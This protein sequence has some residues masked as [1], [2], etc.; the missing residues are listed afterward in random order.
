MERH[1]EIDGSNKDG[2]IRLSF[3]NPNPQRA[4]EIANGYVDQFR[5]LSQQLAISEAS[6]RRLIFEEQLEKTNKDLANAE[7]ALKTR[8]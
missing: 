1:T 5:T 3:E 7:E 6:Q 2:L 8:N 4:A